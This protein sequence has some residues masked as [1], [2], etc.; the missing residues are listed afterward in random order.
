MKFEEYLSHTVDTLKKLDTA[1][2]EKKISQA[3]TAIVQSLKNGLPV[4]VCG[5]GGS[6][7]DAMHISG[8]LVGR[9][10]KERPGLNVICLS[11]NSAFITAWSNDYDYSSIF[12]RQVE[13]YG[14]EGGTIIGLSTSGNS[15]NVIKAFKKAKEMKMCT[16]G[17][18]GQ[19]G[20]NISS[21]STILLEAPSKITPHIQEAHI[22]LYHFICQEVETHMAHFGPTF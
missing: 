14:K 12:E 19:G 15:E 1:D 4:L 22:C 13:S 11:S 18:T 10:F 6:A 3:I 17:L 2:L 9:F 7:A 8:E 5:N 21:V 20:G 16:I